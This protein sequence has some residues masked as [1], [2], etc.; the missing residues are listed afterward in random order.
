[1]FATLDFDVIARSIGYLFYDGMT[2]TLGL[3]LL[4]TL[5][6]GLL[7]TALAMLRL[8]SLPVL[9]HLATLYINLMRSMPL[10]LLIFWVYFMVPYLGQWILGTDRPMQVGTFTSSLLTFTLFEAAYFAEIMR[11]G[12][13]SVSRGQTA[14]A[15]AL[16]L[17]YFQ[18]M[19]HVVLPQAFRAMLPVLLTQV[20]VLFQDTSLVYVLSITDFLGAASKVAQR[21][22]R[23]VEM[24]LFA[25]VV[26]FAISFAASLLVKRIQARTAII[27]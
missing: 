27:R 9:P 7:G 6:G 15:Q 8:S 1:M 5:A 25:A 24:Y 26:Y 12:I 3:T 10:V 2:F 13:Q 4:G 17:T 21:D 20:I 14:A 22:G 16:G 11:S 23:L 19:G 18:S